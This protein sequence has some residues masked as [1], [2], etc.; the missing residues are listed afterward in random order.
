METILSPFVKRFSQPIILSFILAWIF[1]NWK[2]PLGLIWYNNESIC[3]LG[4]YGYEDLIESNSDFGRNYIY[5]IFTAFLYP[6]IILIANN[7]TA[8]V[9]KLDF[10][11]LHIIS[12]DSI[13]P[14]KLYHDVLKVS[15]EREKSISLFVSKEQEINQKLLT[16]ESSNDQLT[17]Q[18][19]LVSEENSRNIEL[20]NVAKDQISDK[21][22]TIGIHTKFSKREWLIGQHDVELWEDSK[23]EF[24]KT[25]YAIKGHFYLTED[26]R[27][28]LELKNNAGELTFEIEK[29]YYDII[30]KKL[31][32]YINKINEH[33]YSTNL[34]S[35]E[36]S[37]AFVLFRDLKY[38]MLEFT[39]SLENNVLRTRV[40][41]DES[42]Y[43]IK[44][45]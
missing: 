22:K 19:R 45:I 12:K 30:N 9:S 32:F 2:I 31:L 8:F 23:N 24:L 29:Y 11:L 27:F 44:I 1:W 35:V 18:L 39:V 38:K 7:F 17:E 16:L 36:D 14:W 33:S 6:V 3:L 4:Y 25:L 34:T 40:K 41:V 26:E 21:T 28:F 42:Y 5:P 37:L 10:K 13:V 15:E 43:E 20:L